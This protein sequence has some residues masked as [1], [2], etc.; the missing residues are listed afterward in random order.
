[1]TVAAQRSSEMP[2]I[3][4]EDNAVRKDRTIPPIQTVRDDG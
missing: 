1:M 2:V 4:A 3:E